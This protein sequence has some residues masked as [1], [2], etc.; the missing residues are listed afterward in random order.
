MKIELQIPEGTA[1]LLTGQY[2]DLPRAALEA[3]VLDGYRT[4][5][6]SDGQLRQMLGFS[7][8]MQVH[9]FLK[10]HGVHLHYSLADLEQ[11]RESSRN[12]EEKVNA[13]NSRAA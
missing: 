12:F 5:R 7:S 2:A 1:H 4:K 3:L 13:G 10:E 6:F 8:R 9:A 11:D